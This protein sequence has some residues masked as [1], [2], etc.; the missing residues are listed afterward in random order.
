[1]STQV[2]RAAFWTNNDGR[3]TCHPAGERSLL[4]IDGHF[5][6]STNFCGRFLSHSAMNQQ[7]CT[8]TSGKKRTPPSA[9]A[10]LCSI[11]DSVNPFRAA[12]S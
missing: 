9:S 5:E 8:G 4:A 10:S 12:L 11:C 1:M 7:N 6:V 3:A 2:R